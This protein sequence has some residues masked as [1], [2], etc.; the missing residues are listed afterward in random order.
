MGRNGKESKENMVQD[1][2]SSVYLPPKK[3]GLKVGS[4]AFHH[5]QIFDVFNFHDSSYIFWRNSS[6]IG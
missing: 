5:I 6:R 4:L 1:A 3:P 2:H